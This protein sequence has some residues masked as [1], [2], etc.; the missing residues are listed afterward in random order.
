VDPLR[1]ADYY[2]RLAPE[3]DQQLSRPGDLW[4]RAAFQEFVRARLDP[5]ARLL[6]FGCGTG[7]DAAWYAAQGYRVLAFDNSEGMIARLRATCAAGIDRKQV[8]PWCG[9]YET[10]EVD[11]GA[12]G[13]IDAVA[14][15]FAVINVL[16]ALGPWFATCR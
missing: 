11:L 14:A 5:G 15:N 13:P 9:A 4:V 16:P 8:E 7:T 3:Y 12:R 2:D 1:S 10:F 6:D